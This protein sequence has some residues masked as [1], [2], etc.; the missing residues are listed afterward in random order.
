MLLS[1]YVIQFLG[2]KGIRDVFLVSGG[3]IMY[4]LDSLARNPGV[5]YTCNYHEQACA[6]AAEGYARVTNGV[7]VCIATTGPGAANAISALPAAWV[8]SV[9]LIVLC[10][11]VKQELIADYAK[12]RQVGPQEGNAVA[13]AAPVTKYAKSIRDPRTIRYELEYAWHQ[14]VSGRPGPVLLELPLDV[15]GAEIDPGTLAG[16]TPPFAAPDPGLAG[17]VA[18]VLAEIRRARRPILICG[19][20]IHRARAQQLLRD[21]LSRLQIPIVLPLTAKDVLEEDHPMQMGIFGV[22]GQRRANFAIQSSDLMLAVG[23]GLN[24]QKVGFNLAG[25]APRA[26]K[27]IVDIDPAQLEHQVVRPDLPILAD[28][29]DFLREML[30][31]LASEPC[32]APQR[33]LDACAR[34]KQRY[35]PVTPDYLEER[36][37][38]NT[39]CF[40]DRLSGILPTDAL[41]V[42]GNALD[43][44]SYFQAFRL[45]RGQRTLNSGW[46]AMGWCLPL[47]IGVCI[48]AGRRKTLCCTGDGSFQFNSQE[49]LT[50]AHQR[51]PIQ[52][53]VFNNQ[54][55]SNIRGTQNNFFQGRFAG[56]DPASGVGTPR[57]DLL[58]AAYDIRYSRIHNHADLEHGIRNALAGDSPGLCEVNVSPTQGIWPKASAFR[59]PDG[60]F[61]SRPLEDM[62]PF[63]PR[64]EIWENMHQFDNEESLERS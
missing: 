34:W 50:I 42:T 28:A 15:Q 2:E 49:L 59:R 39:Y 44:T 18:H 47:A 61:E 52:I 19:N 25:F 55:Y 45:K 11:Q 3:G 21:V 43:T 35:P 14:A 51:L 10:G 41:M 33:W 27:I 16:Y 13:M 24:C 63:L 37:Y 17:Q 29:A 32:S 56:A 26:K 36:D 64:E 1:D 48:G 23:A 46:G 20:G 54:G 38:V 40:Y 53:F 58:A 7:G 6:V 8:D 4:L 12:I 5:R 22:A 60:T 62:A 30:T 9:P 57:F 31:Q